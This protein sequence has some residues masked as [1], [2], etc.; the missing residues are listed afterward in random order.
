MILQLHDCCYKEWIGRSG[1]LPAEGKEQARPC[2]V[3]GSD[4]SLVVQDA[5]PA[6][7]SA[8]FLR[9]RQICLNR[10]YFKDGQMK[11]LYHLVIVLFCCKASHF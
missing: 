4:G 10:Y 11:V 9:V 7:I 6:E 1:F 8:L 5:P 3:T 2:T